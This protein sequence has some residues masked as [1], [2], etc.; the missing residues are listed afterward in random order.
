[1]AP[2]QLVFGQFRLFDLIVNAN[3]VKAVSDYLWTETGDD[4]YR[5]SPRLAA[6]VEAGRLGL[7]SGAGWFDHPGDPGTLEHERDLAIARAY[8]ALADL[9]RADSRGHPRDG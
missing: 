1:M 8:R 2:R 5:P 3:T 6:Q 4:R 9:E 7:V